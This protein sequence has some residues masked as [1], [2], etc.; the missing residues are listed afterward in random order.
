ML[1]PLTAIPATGLQFGTINVTAVIDVP[2]GMDIEEPRG[3]D[4]NIRVIKPDTAPI[5]SR[6]I[7][8]SITAIKLNPAIERNCP[9]SSESG[10]FIVI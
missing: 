7:G 10:Q 1:R 9:D 8:L 6:T 3:M 4:T 2:F 5:T